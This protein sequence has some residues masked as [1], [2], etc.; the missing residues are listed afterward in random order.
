MVL[1]RIMALALVALSVVF[2]SLWFYARAARREKLE[3]QWDENQGPGRRE[4]F[5]K[6]ELHAY[7]GPLK[8]KL[9]W[10][11]YVIPLCLIALLIYVTNTV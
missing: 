5:V 9:I 7:E 10:G 2:V 11:V 6:A 1:A 3:A 8:R 4:S